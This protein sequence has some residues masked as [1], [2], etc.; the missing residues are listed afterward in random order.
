MTREM[1]FVGAQ[2]SAAASREFVSYSAAF[3]R[4]DASIVLDTL[5]DSVAGELLLS[6]FLV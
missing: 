4:G 6:F 1:D 2:L 5:F 3:L